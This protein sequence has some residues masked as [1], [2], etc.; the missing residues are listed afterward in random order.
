MK[1]TVTSRCLNAMSPRLNQVFL[2]LIN[3][4]AQ[5]IVGG[6][7]I[8]VRTQTTP[9][10]NVQIEVEDTG[11]GIPDDILPHIFNLYFTTKLQGEGTGMGLHIAKDI[12]DHHGGKIRGAD[13]GR[14]GI[15]IYGDPTSQ[16]R[17]PLR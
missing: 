12:I 10:G 8:W 4:A 7:Q 6:G 13:K 16:S 14:R 17:V 5:S 11:S 15:G 1:R 9:Q 2:N 3:N